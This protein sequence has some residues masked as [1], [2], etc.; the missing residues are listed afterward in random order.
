MNHPK[1]GRLMIISISG[2]AGSG[3]S[4]VATLLAQRLGYKHYSTGDIRRSMATK[5]GLSLKEFNALGEKEAFTDKEVDD[6]QREL[7]KKEDNFVIDGRLG[8]HFIP[9]SIKIFLD[10]DVRIRAQRVFKA[11][12]KDEHFRDVEQA[13]QEIEKREQ[14]DIRRYQK[15]YG[16]NHFEKSQYD[17]VIDTSSKIPAQIVEEIVT[18]LHNNRL[19]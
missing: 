9:H 7:G 1:K 15:Y 11:F 14:S 12:R 3:K 8:F 10:A 17:H 18:L 2:S 6:Y 13:M 5:M 16:I 19:H 4:S